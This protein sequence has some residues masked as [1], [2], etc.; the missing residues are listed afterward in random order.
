MQE[1]ER[2]RTV[3]SHFPLSGEVTSIERYGDGHINTTYLVT[4]DKQRYILQQMNTEIFPDTPGLMRNIEEV[5]SFLRL[6]GK[7]T[8]EIIHTNEGGSYDVFE[9]HCYRV[10]AFI[11]H[12]ISYNLVPNG[13]VFSD[14]G[15]AFGE[16]QNYLAQFDAAKL[17]QTI[18]H[19]HDTPRRYA[20]L[21]RAIEA[22]NM[23]RVDMCMDEIAFFMDRAEQYG[24]IM[25]ALADGSV[26]LRV[27]H[28][29][30]KLNNILMDATTH[31]PRAIIDLDTVMPGSMLFD[32]GDS[33]RFGASTALEDERDLDTVHF[34]TELF[35]AYAQGFVGEVASSITPREV[36]LLPMSARLMTCECGMR[37]LTDFLQG[38]TYF[39]TKYPEHNLVRTRTQRKLVQDMEKETTTMRNI[40]DNILQKAR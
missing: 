37:F 30:T 4:T 23:H 8:L 11:E 15:A 5:T 27:T 14:A 35:E 17:S 6:Q 3:A 7:E 34:S 26:P 19:F 13:E 24:C 20:N 18:A 31:K 22:D 29:D 33:I 38:D 32:F 39:A 10:Y 16:F 2:L 40:V 21:Q 36:E 28:N 1:I 12:T 25:D 9:Q